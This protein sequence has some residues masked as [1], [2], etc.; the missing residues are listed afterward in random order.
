MTLGLP[1][2]RARRIPRSPLARA[3]VPA[4]LAGPP[5]MPR[6][7]VRELSASLSAAPPAGSPGLRAEPGAAGA[8]EE[9]RNIPGRR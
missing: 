9:A 4:A 5:E 1:P 2:L 6:C 8:G 3:A 7:F